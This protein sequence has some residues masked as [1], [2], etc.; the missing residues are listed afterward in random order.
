[1]IEIKKQI[2]RLKYLLFSIVEIKFLFQVSIS[3][4]AG[5]VV[6]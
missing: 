3:V 4:Q 2:P 5:A 6:R 1:M